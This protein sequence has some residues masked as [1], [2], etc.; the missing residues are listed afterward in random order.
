MVRQCSLKV[1]IFNIYSFASNQKKFPH[2]RRLMSTIMFK[3]KMEVDWINLLRSST[4]E[5][6]VVL[7]ESCTYGKPLKTMRFLTV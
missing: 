7:T 2:L 1:C 3:K 5:R 6:E 4:A